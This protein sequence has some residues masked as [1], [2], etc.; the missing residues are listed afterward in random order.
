MPLKNSEKFRVTIGLPNG[1]TYYAYGYVVPGKRGYQMITF[2]PD[3]IEPPRFKQFAQSFTLIDAKANTPPPDVSGIFGICLVWG[4]WGAVV[5]R[6]YVRRGG[7][8]ATRNE[9]ATLL[10]LVGVGIAVLVVAG[11]RGVLSESLGAL[12]VR[13][14]GVILALWE[15]ARWRV[16]R[17]NPLRNPSFRDTKPQ[18]GIIYTDSELEAMKGRGDVGPFGGP[19]ATHDSGPK[20]TPASAAAGGHRGMRP[21]RPHGILR[22]GAPTARP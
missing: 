9:K 1:S 6:R 12:T 21:Q 14:G 3:P 16:R 19:A 8:R 22:S 2:S 20:P 11:S 5:N 10:A 13:I 4:C 17:R 15:L 18:K 7:V